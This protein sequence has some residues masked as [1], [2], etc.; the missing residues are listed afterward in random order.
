MT[1]KTLLKTVA[2]LPLAIFLLAL[3]HFLL[4]L[5]HNVVAAPGP[6]GPPPKPV[7]PHVSFVGC[8]DAPQLLAIT[9]SIPA[10]LWPA[11]THWVISE[12]DETA[13]PS[14]VAPYRR[15]GITTANN[16]FLVYS[17]DPAAFRGIF[18]RSHAPDGSPPSSILCHEL[19]HVVWPGLVDPARGSDVVNPILYFFG[20]GQYEYILPGQ[21]SHTEETFADAFQLNRFDRAHAGDDWGQQYIDSLFSPVPPY[22]GKPIQSPVPIGGPVLPRPEPE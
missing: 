16:G 17:T 2:R 21:P 13:W 11:G 14:I 5:C 20:G 3:C 1:L 15:Y 19:G 18:I 6:S 12:Y 22:I 9:N 10:S 4:A 7:A 8:P